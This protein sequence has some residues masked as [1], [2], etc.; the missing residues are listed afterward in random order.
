MLVRALTEEMFELLRAFRRTAQIAEL[1]SVLAQ[2]IPQRFLLSGH[3]SMRLSLADCERFERFLCGLF[4]Y[5]PR[6]RNHLAQRLPQL[7]A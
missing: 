5:V 4:R 6:I 3:A 2:S 1:A 7:A